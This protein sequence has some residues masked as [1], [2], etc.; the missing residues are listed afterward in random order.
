MN[1][2]VNKFATIALLVFF[3]QSSFGQV[4]QFK[5]FNVEEGLSN[6]YVYTVAEDNN[7]FVWIQINKDETHSIPKGLPS[8]NVIRWDFEQIVSWLKT[9]S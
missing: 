4:Y 7:G 5:E 3:V 8:K 9:W 2:S 6:P 1:S